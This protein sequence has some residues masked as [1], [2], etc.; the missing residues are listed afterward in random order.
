MKLK[1]YLDLLQE[2]N[3]VLMPFFFG[4]FLSFLTRVFSLFVFS[5]FETETS[6]IVVTLIG[7]TTFL[8]I[9]INFLVKTI[10]NKNANAFLVFTFTYLLYEFVVFPMGL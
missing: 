9:S 5:V 1:K 8:F 4:A 6:V 2:E 7:F 10:K 3:K